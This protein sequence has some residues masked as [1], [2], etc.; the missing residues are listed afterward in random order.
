MSH[1]S[2]FNE[3]IQSQGAE[4]QKFIEQTHIHAHTFT[5]FSTVIWGF[6]PS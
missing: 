5:H 3:G 6:Y 4:T 2:G 1:I